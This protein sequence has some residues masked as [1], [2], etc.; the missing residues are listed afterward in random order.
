MIFGKKDKRIVRID[1]YR[2][3]VVPQGYMLLVSANEDKPGLLGALGTLLGNFS[4]NIMAV[5]LAR[6]VAGGES[7]VVLNL[8][9]V[10]SEEAMKKI[11]SLGSIS[12]ASL[13][14]LR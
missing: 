9:S 7:I 6:D 3:D 13:V 5:S 1:N 2:I 11:M 8:D 14:N 4:I 12:R 10:V